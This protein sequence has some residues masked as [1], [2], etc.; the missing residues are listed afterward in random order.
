MSWLLPYPLL[1]AAL[2]ALWL[3]LNQSLSP[4]HLVLGS[5]LAVLASWAMVIVV[6]TVLGYALSLLQVFTGPENQPVNVQSEGFSAYILSGQKNIAGTIFTILIGLAINYFL[7]RF[8]S[9]VN[10]SLNGVSPEKF[11]ASFRNLKIYFA[12]TTVL[13]LLV[14]LILLIVASALI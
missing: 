6:V 8:A 10:S 4:G 14:M 13:L 1:S 3:L 11:N 9:T 5:I 12:I 7:Y 2:L